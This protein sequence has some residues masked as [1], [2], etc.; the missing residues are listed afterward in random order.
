MLL[1]NIFTIGFILFNSIMEVN[2]VREKPSLKKTVIPR[3]KPNSPKKAPI[4]ITPILEENSVDESVGERIIVKTKTKTGDIFYESDSSDSDRPVFTKVPLT[5][6]DSSDLSEIEM[7]PTKHR[8]H[9]HK[10]KT[11][12]MTEI[13]ETIGDI[14][15]TLNETVTEVGR[16]A[17]AGILKRIVKSK[18]FTIVLI[19]ATL[20]ICVGYLLKI[21]IK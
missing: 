10:T 11:P 19:I 1:I 6:D 5:A 4:S 16:T 18:Q 8:K 14:S 2:S 9:R 20:T 21:V 13:T 15:N 7:K 12:D 3:E 17:V